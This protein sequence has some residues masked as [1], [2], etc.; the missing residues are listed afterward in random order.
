MM[1][2]YGRLGYLLGYYEYFKANYMLLICVFN[3]FYFLRRDFVEH[4]YFGEETTFK[5]FWSIDKF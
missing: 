1:L 3:I 4:E 5:A 2:F